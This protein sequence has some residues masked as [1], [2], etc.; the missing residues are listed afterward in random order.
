MTIIEKYRELTENIVVIEVC[1][2]QI[3]RELSILIH[4]YCP[5]GV[6]AIDYSKPAVQTSIS[7]K[8][9]SNVNIKLHDLET[10][11]IDLK[12]EKEFLNKQ[13]DKLEK[14]INDLGDIEKK[15]MVLRIKGKRNWE[16][17]EILNY[18]EKGIE[19]IFRRIRKKQKV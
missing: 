18:T 10:E 17:A 4:T 7:Q 19:Y 2:E 15:V 16:I 14:N 12:N 8:S 9:I 5:S 13:R 6:G 1:I 11:L 3:Y